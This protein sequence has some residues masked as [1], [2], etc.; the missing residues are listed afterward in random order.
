VIQAKWRQGESSDHKQVMGAA[1][2]R[3]GPNLRLLFQ[4]R[5]LARI[6]HTRRRV[7]AHGLQGQGFAS[8][9]RVPSRGALFPFPLECETGGLGLT[10][11]V[12]VHCLRGAF[13]VA[14]SEN[15][16]GGAADDVAAGEHARKTGHALVVHDDVPPL[17]KLEVRA[18]GR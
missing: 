4:G 14:H 17:I 13:A 6:F 16:R 15:N 9:G 8:V 2:H 1:P 10:A 3:S 5:W 11:Q 12:L 18:G 7:G